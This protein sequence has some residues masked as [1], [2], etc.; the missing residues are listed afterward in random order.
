MDF[1][2]KKD[3][4]QQGVGSQMFWEDRSASL[5]CMGWS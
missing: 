5:C 1:G 3:E 2:V 4:R